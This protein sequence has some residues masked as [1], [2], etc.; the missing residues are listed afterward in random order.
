[1]SNKVI[2]ISAN[3]N[4]SWKLNRKLFN[5]A[6]R[7]Y[8]KPSKWV[9]HTDGRLPFFSYWL[10]MPIQISV[11]FYRKLLNILGFTKGNQGPWGDWQQVFMDEKWKKTLEELDKYN[12]GVEWFYDKVEIKTLLQS[13]VL[14]ASQKMNLLQIM[15]RL[16]RTP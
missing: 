3:V 10:N 2:K 8:L 4:T 11:I 1:M 6:L 5:K 7:P 13:D 15:D 9:L 14:T 12:D 16:R